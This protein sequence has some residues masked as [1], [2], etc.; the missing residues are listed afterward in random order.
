M[1]ITSESQKQG[2]FTPEVVSWLLILLSFAIFGLA[3]QQQHVDFGKNREL[4]KLKGQIADFREQVVGICFAKRTMRGFERQRFLAGDWSMRAADIPIEMRREMIQLQKGIS[5]SEIK[6]EEEHESVFKWYQDAAAT[7]TQANWYWQEEAHK[8][9]NYSD[10][11]LRHKLASLLSVRGHRWLEM[12]GAVPAA[13]C[14]ARNAA[15]SVSQDRRKPACA[16]FDSE[17]STWNMRGT[18]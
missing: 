15:Y 14:S 4:L 7:G 9:G 11:E 18:M 10:E 2:I 3:L 12:G 6:D 13:S 16:G 17:L 5:L 8:R 1:V